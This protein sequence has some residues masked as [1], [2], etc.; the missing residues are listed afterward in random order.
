MSKVVSKYETIF[1][2]DPKVDEESTREIINKFKELIEANGTLDGVDEWGKRRL[3]YEIND[4]REGYYVLMNFTAPTSFP[5]ELDR[6]YKITEGIMRSII[7]V[8]E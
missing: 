2:V 7:I 8:K 4:E 3:A 6:V 1:I 5:Q